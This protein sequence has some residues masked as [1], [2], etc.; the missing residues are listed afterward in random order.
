MVQELDMTETTWHTCK[1][2]AK[3]YIKRLFSQTFLVLKVAM[4]LHFGKLSLKGRN[5]TSFPSSCLLVAVW[6]MHVMAGALA[7]I[8]D[9]EIKS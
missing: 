4:P 5:M 8:L 3:G 2:I 7:V 6:N 1:H 9:Y